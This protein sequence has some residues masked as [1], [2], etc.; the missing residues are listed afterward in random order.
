MVGLIWRAGL[1]LLLLVPQAWAD[2]LPR[3]RIFLLEREGTASSWLFGTMH[4]SDP[5]VLVLPPEVRVALGRSRV[6]VGELNLQDENIGEIMLA[7]LLPAGQTLEDLLPPALYERTMAALG[8]AGMPSYLAERFQPWMAAVVLSFDEAEL[9]RQRKGAEALD[10]RLQRLARE[11]GKAVIGLESA[12][13]QLAIFQNLP[14]E[15]QIDY[16]EMALSTPALVGG[17]DGWVKRLYLQ[18]DHRNM[19][20]AYYLV[21]RFAQT[22]F[23]DHFT[24]KA[25]IDR[26]LLMAERLAPI[27]AEGG[28]FV[29]VGALHLPGPQGLF[30]LLQQQGWRI[31]PLP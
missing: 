30:A 21:T 12:A 23:V 18:G 19:W 3:A 29:A 15:W 5:E 11:R 9:E 2:T 10:D 6:V 24:Q 13:E 26:N 14:L 7:T 28:A 25:I 20:G 17:T 16:L 1:L 4:S 8:V 22:P 31:T 27:L